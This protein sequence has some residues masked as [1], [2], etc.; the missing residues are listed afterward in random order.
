MTSEDEEIARQIVEGWYWQ[1]SEGHRYRF[2]HALDGMVLYKELAPTEADMVALVT[3]YIRS[4]SDV[5]R[6][7]INNKLHTYEAGWD[8]K[9]CWFTTTPGDKY[10]GSDAEK[11]RIYWALVRPGSDAANGDGPYTV[12]NGCQYAVSHEFYWDVAALP[13]VPQG[14]SGISYTLQGVTRDRET[15]YFSCVVERRE[16]VAQHVAKYLSETNAFEDVSE[17]QHLGV[18]QGDPSGSAASCANGTIVTR[19]VSKNPDC[20]TDVVNVTTVEKSVQEAVVSRAETR[21]GT[22]ETIENRNMPSKAAADTL[23][24]GETVTNEQTKGRRWNQRIVRLLRAAAVKVRES[25]RKTTFAHVHVKVENRKTDPGFSHV[26]AAANGVIVEKSVERTAEGFDVTEERTEETPVSGAVVETARSLRAVSRSVTDRNQATVPGAAD[27]APGERMSVRKTDGGRNDV[28]ITTVTPAGVGGTIGE[29]CEKNQ[30]RH[31]HSVTKNEAAVQPVEIAESE[32]VNF[33]RTRTVRKTDENTFDVTE[34]TTRHIPKSV[35]FRG[36]RNG[37][38]MEMKRVGVNIPEVADDREIGANTELLRS[39]SPNAHG[40]LTVEETLRTH[41]QKKFTGVAT[42][43]VTS[44]EIETTVNCTGPVTAAAGANEEI[45]LSISPNP[46]GTLTVQKHKRKF[47]QRSA[48]GGSSTAIENVVETT[49][50]DNP[51]PETPGSENVFVSNR[52]NAH[53]SFDTTRRT[54]TPK[55]KRETVQWTSEEY[56]GTHTHNGERTHSFRRYACKLVVFRNMQSMP[57]PSANGSVSVSVSINQYG[58]LDGA[59][60]SKVYEG[61]VQKNY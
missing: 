35:V 29:S 7:V 18:K 37:L 53:G 14:E 52:P 46:H 36:G 12:E 41:L 42:G 21:N 39:A 17:A 6:L 5:R 2:R 54:V 19:K 38:T 3:E 11:I 51:S 47:N 4:R 22:I 57:P 43:A 15:G 56:A 40:S 34:Q 25:C 10:E 27:L 55:A 23:A 32:E 61:M 9:D 16:R 60:S 28:T 45:S 48:T 44:D 50:I 31:V 33:E 30:T 1:P 8:T 49:S 58:L 20:T 59:I 24:P 26:A 13:S